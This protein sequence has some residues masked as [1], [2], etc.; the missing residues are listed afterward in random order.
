MCPIAHSPSAVLAGGQMPR[1]EALD[2]RFTKDFGFIPIPRRLRYNP[3]EPFHFGIFLNISFGFASTFSESIKYMKRGD[4][5][6]TKYCSRGQ[7]VL[8]PTSVE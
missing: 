1:A 3:E 2:A 4:I 7:F 5:L 8:L 6:I